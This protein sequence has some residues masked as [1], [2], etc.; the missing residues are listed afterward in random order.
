MKALFTRCFWLHVA[1]ILFV[2]LG[3]IGMALPVMPTTVFFILA[4]YCFTR[5]N[6]QLA[7]W[8][9]THPKFGPSLQLWQQHQIIPIK[10]KC[11]AGTGML[12]GFA[13]L[14]FSS[15]PI[16]VIALVACIEIAVLYYIC[17]RPSAAPR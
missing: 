6:P 13:L 9:L 5:S 16:W 15:A 10:G 11:L 3:F 14:C 7:N 8:L 1:G 2:V 17:T 4:L 12:I